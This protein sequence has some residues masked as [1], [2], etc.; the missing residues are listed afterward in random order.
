MSGAG[1]SAGV[2]TAQ[3]SV[4]APPRETAPARTARS[5]V[6]R[7]VRRITGSV[8]GIVKR[9][10]DGKS[11][12]RAVEQDSWEEAAARHP[13]EREHRAQERKGQEPEHEPV[14]EREEAAAQHDGAL[15]RVHPAE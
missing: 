4:A 6:A 9:V 14:D 1:P 3:P 7:Q 15:D 2:A 8:E 11:V 5:A 13:H 12:V 10:P